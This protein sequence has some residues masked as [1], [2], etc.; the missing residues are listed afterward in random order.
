MIN[1]TQ[2]WDKKYNYIIL[3]LGENIEIL[4][5]NAGFRVAKVR[6]WPGKITIFEGQEKVSNFFF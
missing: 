6:K 2:A 5:N 3:L 4:L 1:I